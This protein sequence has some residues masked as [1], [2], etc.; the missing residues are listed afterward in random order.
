MFRHTL[1]SLL[2][3]EAIVPK[4]SEPLQRVSE[5]ANLKISDLLIDCGRSSLIVQNGKGNK[6]RVVLITSSFKRACLWYLH[7]KRKIMQRTDE[8]AYLLTDRNSNKLTTRA[9]QKDFKK[10][11]S[12]AGLSMHY[13]IHCLR[14]T[15][16]SHL[17][18]ASNHNLRLVQEQLGHSSVRVTEVYASL[19]NR[20]A[21]ESIER[22]YK[23]G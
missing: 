5:M 13:S 23:K 17:Y 11:L 20:E 12:K 14:H 19:M 4:S 21:K 9:L 10:C 16:G 2:L 22:L 15:Y 8:Q 7:W 6:K 3:Y 18:E 1:N